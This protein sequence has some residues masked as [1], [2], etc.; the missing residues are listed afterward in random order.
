MESAGSVGSCGAFSIS[1]IRETRILLGFVFSFSLIFGLCA[2]A[3]PCFTG[4]PV[5]QRYSRVSQR[6]TAPAHIRKIQLILTVTL[7]DTVTVSS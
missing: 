6:N 3:R 4:A 1:N 2:V 7:I 5:F